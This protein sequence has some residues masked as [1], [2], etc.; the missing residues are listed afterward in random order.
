LDLRRELSML[1]EKDVWFMADEGDSHERTSMA[2]GASE[3]VWGKKLLPEAHRDLA[4]IALTIARYE[5]TRG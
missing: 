1:D 4:A 3:Q 2:L 5:L